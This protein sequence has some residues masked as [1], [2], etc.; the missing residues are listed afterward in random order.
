VAL[1][2]PSAEAAAVSSEQQEF[3]IASNYYFSGHDYKL[4]ADLRK[5]DDRSTADE[6]EVEVRVQMQFT[7]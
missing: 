2:D 1:T 5:I 3:G 7:F 4:Q 6:D